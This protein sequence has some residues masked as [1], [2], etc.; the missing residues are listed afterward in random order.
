MAPCPIDTPEGPLGPARGG[1]PEN[2]PRALAQPRTLGLLTS[3]TQGLKLG[4]A[5]I[6]VGKKPMTAVPSLTPH[7]EVTAGERLGIPSWFC[8]QTVTHV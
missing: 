7:S 3:V 5:Q 2:R 6:N 1:E 4:G 8:T